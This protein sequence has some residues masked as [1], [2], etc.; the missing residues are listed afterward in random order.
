MDSSPSYFNTG[1]Q[2]V[3]L[4]PC[5]EEQMHVPTKQRGCVE[6]L[7]HRNSHKGIY[8]ILCCET[9]RH[10]YKSPYNLDSLHYGHKWGCPSIKFLQQII[11]WLL[12]DEGQWQQKLLMWGLVLLKCV[13]YNYNACIHNFT[14]NIHAHYIDSWRGKAHPSLREHDL[15]KRLVTACLSMWL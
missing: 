12:D 9:G 15:N 10:M 3:V 1:L 2:T 14:V 6:L 7:H 5:R 13:H 8:I 4:V 11:L